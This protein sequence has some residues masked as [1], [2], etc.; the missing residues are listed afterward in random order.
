MNIDM[1]AR[2]LISHE[3]ARKEGDLFVIG[4]S[5]H[6]QHALGDIVFVELP[7]KGT[8]IAKGKPFGVVESVKAASDVYMPISGTVEATND[9]LGGDPATINRDPYNAGWLIK[10]KPS[11]PS[12]F[13]TLLSPA[14]YEAQIKE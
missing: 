5:D 9:V 4:I 8:S 11:N 12:E 14:D 3:W 10:V 13:D 7:K 1:N 2:Y 6:A